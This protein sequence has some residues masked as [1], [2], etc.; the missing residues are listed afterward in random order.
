MPWENDRWIWP[1]IRRRHVATSSHHS[2]VRTCGTY[3]D[4]RYIY[5]CVYFVLSPCTTK[6]NPKY[7]RELYTASALCQQAS[8]PSLN[9]EPKAALSM[10]SSTP[11]GRKRIQISLA[12]NGGEV[13][14]FLRIALVCRVIWSFCPVLPDSCMRNYSAIPRCV[15]K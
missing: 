13:C 15:E 3:E 6:S 10:A 14:T 5:T 4:I 9:Q 11:V 8:I 1:L 12:L 2:A 7:Y